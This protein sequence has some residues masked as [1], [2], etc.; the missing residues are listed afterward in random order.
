MNS[1]E[2]LAAFAE[3]TEQYDIDAWA[4]DDHR[5][6]TRHRAH[7]AAV[8]R[9]AKELPRDDVKRIWDSMINRKMLSASPEYRQEYYWGSN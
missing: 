6:Y 1:V 3:L 8:R 9:A 5:A 7:M 2:K 4:S